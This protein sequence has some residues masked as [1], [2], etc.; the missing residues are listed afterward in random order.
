MQFAFFRIVMVICRGSQPCRKR[1]FSASPT[2]YRLQ[3]TRFAA[4][5]PRY[6][7]LFSASQD[8]SS[9]NRFRHRLK[10]SFVLS[11]KSGP[12]AC[13]KEGQLRPPH[14]HST[15]GFAVAVIGPSEMSDPQL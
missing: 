7:R 11:E 4:K 13:N 1:I 3:L 12:Y 14:R 15:C 6:F 8:V 10:R 2:R 9:L 5:R